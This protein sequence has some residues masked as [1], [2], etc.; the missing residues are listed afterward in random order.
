MRFQLRTLLITVLLAAIATP[1]SIRIYRHYNPRPFFAGP[2]VILCSTD[3]RDSMTNAHITNLLSSQGINSITEGSTAYGTTIEK[4]RRADA[5]KLLKKSETDS[6]PT[7]KLQNRLGVLF[8][9]G[10]KSQTFTEKINVHI[11][12]ITESTNRRANLVLAIKNSIPSSYLAANRL[13]IVV[14]LSGFER[15]YLDEDGAMQ[16]GYTI[17]IDLADRVDN[18]TASFTERYQIMND[19]QDVQFLVGNGTGNLPA[20][21]LSPEHRRNFELAD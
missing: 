7:I 10:D 19:C 2:T 9:T 16:T 6:L 1:I 11:N 4:P 20:S 12:D 15:K 3:S 18:P 21:P 14:A 5:I 13:P 8:V 17:E